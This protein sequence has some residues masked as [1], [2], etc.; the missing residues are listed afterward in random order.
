MRTR[1]VRGVHNEPARRRDRYEPLHERKRLHGLVQLVAICHH[2]EVPVEVD[3]RLGEALARGLTDAMP[4][5]ED[6][7]ERRIDGEFGGVRLVDGPPEATVTLEPHGIAGFREAEHRQMS[8]RLRRVDRPHG[9][10]VRTWAA[11]N[12]GRGGQG[13]SGR[14]GQCTGAARFSSTAARIGAP[15]VSMDPLDRVFENLD[16]WRHLPAYQME[17]RADIF[18]SV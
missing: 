9:A 4:L 17:R 15:M 16:R 10:L 1:V 8:A 7:L 13:T 3:A 5:R 18:F 2:A 14:S 11:G 12:Q 6:G